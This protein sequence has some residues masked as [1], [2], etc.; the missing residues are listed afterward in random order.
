MWK[1]LFIMLVAVELVIAGLA[2]VKVSQIMTA[3]K[4]GPK[5][6]PPPPA[7]S[8]VVARAQ[9]WQP[10]LNAIGSLKSV[11]GV[12]V[13]TDLAGIVSEIA[14]QS[15]AAVKKGDLLVRLDTKQELAQLHSAEA[16]RQ[17]SVLNLARQRDLLAKKAASQSEYDT[18]AAQARQ[19]GRR[20][21]GADCAQ[22]HYSAV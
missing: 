6:A 21:Q 1:R 15:G 12:E 20:I 14:F 7:V 9:K 8:T 19:D 11:N 4:E 10:T 18:V 13:S 3:M 2:F 16:R 5:H 17:L 22:S